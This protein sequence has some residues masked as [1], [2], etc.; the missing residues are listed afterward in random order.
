M[1]SRLDADAAADAD[2]TA[3]ITLTPPP[4]DAITFS[5]AIYAYYAL[6]P[7]TPLMP[8]RCRHFI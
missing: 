1:P 6:P 2:I 5:I 8:L 4:L 3:A 7:F